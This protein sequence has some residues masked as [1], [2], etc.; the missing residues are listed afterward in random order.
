MIVTVEEGRIARIEGDPANPATGGHVCLKG[1]AYA[2]RVSSPDRL[3]HPLRRKPAGGFERVSWDEAIDDIAARLAQV[4]TTSG[5]AAALYYDASGSHGALGRL[6]MAFWHQFGGCTLT[7]GDLCWPAGLEAT[8]LT[9]GANLHNHP[10]LTAESRFILLWGHNPAETNVHQWRLAL[11]AQARGARIAVVDPRGT[12]TTDAADLHLQPRPGTDAAL[13]LGLARVIVDE[14]LHDRAFLD[15]HAHGVDR[16]LERLREYPLDRVA[17]ITGLSEAAIRELALAYARTRPA[18][19]VAGFGLQRNHHAGQT[20]RAVALLPALTGNVGVAGG[21]WQYANLASHVLVEPPLPPEPAGVRRAIP[22][23][24][25]G[26]GLAELEAPRVAA[27]WVEKGN[28]AS[29][30]PRSNLVRDA[31]SRLDLLV[32]VDQFMTDTARLAHYVLPAKT[33][34]EE[35]D[36]C[37][38]YWHP[39]LQRRAKVFEPPGEVKTETAIWRLLCARFGFDTSWFPRDDRE[40]R[41]MVRR[42]LPPGLTLEQLEA[43]PGLA[44][45]VA[46]VAFEDGRFATPS[47]RIEFASEQAARAWS[48][49]PVPGYAPL[50]EGHASGLAGRFPLQL[51]SCKTRDRIHSQFGNLDW[52]REV[53]RPHLLDVHPSDAAAR[54]LAEGDLAAVWN[55]RGRI[56]LR[57]RLDEGLRPGVV[58]VLEGRCHEGDPDVNV[59]TGDGVTDM[60]HGAT[61]YE[62]LVEVARAADSPAPAA[63]S[64][65]AGAR[66]SAAAA[67]PAGESHACRAGLQTRR[68]GGP[69]GPPRPAFL[70]DLARCIGCAACVLACRL[71]NG[72]SSE[73]P[74]RRVLPLNLRR[75]PGGP[76]YFLS[77]ACHHCARPA[78]LAAC[79]SGAYEQRA[80]GI[81]VHH[82][83]RC[84]GCRY[85]EMACPFGAPRY[86][87]EK[88]VVSKC[89]LC[90]HRL[91]GGELPACVAACPTEALRLAGDEANPAEHDDEAARDRADGRDARLA[92]VPGFADPAACEPA[93]RFLRPRGA[94]REALL[95]ALEER[96]RR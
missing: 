37:T 19:L 26:Q 67:V 27:A 9:Y 71:E 43:G 86:S 17:S 57:V 30:N 70:L 8:R 5:P 65:A 80:D 14:G 87:Q 47:G 23:A 28:P 34:F 64:R 90:R 51:L 77:V 41:A 56:E 54:G 53:E 33:L 69:S 16:Y 73:A 74:W 45:G 94:R 2:R 61:F 3:L 25:L 68:T 15:A 40:T 89:H 66:P 63:R 4:R 52:V 20:M 84:L 21:G 10:R 31:L 78:C 96:L 48:V 62:C 49:A 7:Y 59:L 46:D 29:Q 50:P 91:D 44:P 55:D 39:Y 18:L 75:R 83:E 72:T 13:A 60:N 24:R 76:T 92:I 79:P 36:V 11:D 85:C 1:I 88:K 6:A 35:E 81:V 38:A 22:V 12:D 93:T 32:V 58:H 42:M 95:R 82:E